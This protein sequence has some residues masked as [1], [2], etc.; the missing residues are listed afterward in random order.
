MVMPPPARF[1]I[2]PK[3]L[4]TPRIAGNCFIRVYREIRTTLRRPSD[5]AR[6]TRDKQVFFADAA[7]TSVMSILRQAARSAG[8]GRCESFR[9]GY[10]LSV[11]LRAA[12]T[13]NACF[14]EPNQS[15]A[16]IPI[17]QQN[18]LYPG[19]GRIGKTVP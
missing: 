1:G 3:N 12:I 4:A 18:R 5:P 9:T 7:K 6:T 16:P 11:S 8:K 19:I 17:R 14:S 2:F 15:Y 13:T 10:L